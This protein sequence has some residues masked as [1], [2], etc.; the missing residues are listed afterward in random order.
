MEK[1]H[2]EVTNTSSDG[3]DLRALKVIK[4]VDLAMNLWQRYLSNVFMTLSSSSVT[5]RRE[6][7]TYNYNILVLIEDKIDAIDEYRGTQYPGIEIGDLNGRFEMLMVVAGVPHWLSL[8]SSSS[9][10]SKEGATDEC[11]WFIPIT[12]NDPNLNQGQSTGFTD[13]DESGGG[14]DWEHLSHQGFGL[15]KAPLLKI[16]IIFFQTFLMFQALLRTQNQRE[17]IK[18]VVAV[19]WLDEFLKPTYDGYGCMA[20]G[21]WRIEIGTVRGLNKGFRGLRQDKDSTKIK[22]QKSRRYRIKRLRTIRK[23]SRAVEQ[24]RKA[25]NSGKESIGVKKSPTKARSFISLNNK[26]IIKE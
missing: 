11:S 26:S 4:L 8:G 25:E 5:V 24:D 13:L 21:G 17:M 6:L 18:G 14:L 1:E 3:K 15:F 16:A 22:G 7:L 10:Q 9:S 20:D 2:E 19:R 12:T 23:K